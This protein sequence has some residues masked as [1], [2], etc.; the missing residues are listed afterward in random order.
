MRDSRPPRGSHPA[1]TFWYHNNWDFNVLGSIYRRRT[2]E[3]IFEAIQSRIAAP[4]GMQEYRV[5]DG[6]Y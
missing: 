3:D 5:A 2:G 4:I 1:G 6:Q